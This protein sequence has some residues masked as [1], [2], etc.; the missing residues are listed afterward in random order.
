M[1]D[2]VYADLRDEEVPTNLLTVLRQLADELAAAEAE[3]A[4][5]EEILQQRKNMLK[6]IVEQR[7]P[8]ATEGMDGK[9]DLKDGRELIIKEEIRSSIAGDKREPAIEWLDANGYGSIVKRQVIFEFPKGSTDRCNKFL[10][11]VQSLGLGQ[12][13][14]KTKYEVHHATLNSWV[15]ERLKEGDEIPTDTFGVF[16]QRIAKVKGEK[17]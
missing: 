14:M 4:A 7:I 3:V 10:E 5:A 6:D 17:D 2:D 11:A 8:R 16:R 12:L 13:V 9:L 15:K 1:S